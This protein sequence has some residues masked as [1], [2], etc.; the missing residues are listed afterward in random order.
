MVLGDIRRF[1]SYRSRKGHFLWY[2]GAMKEDDPLLRYV[3]EIAGVFGFIAFGVIIVTVI[4]IIMNF[5]I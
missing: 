4:A 2:N 1:E 5:V 3:K